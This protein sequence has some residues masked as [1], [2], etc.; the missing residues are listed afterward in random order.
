MLNTTGNIIIKIDAHAKIPDNFIQANVDALLDGEF[1]C[2]GGR[3]NIPV[4]ESPWDNVLLAAEECMFGGS[5]AKYR[6]PQTKREYIN[7]IFNGAYRREV[8][9][10]SAAL[11][12]HLVVLKTMNFITE[13][14][15]Q[16]IK[17]AVTLTL[18]RINTLEAV[19]LKW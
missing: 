15:K 2:G 8:L 7:S 16:A 3:P 1:V 5:F 18:F 9:L 4:K 6:N 14:P 12:K 19:Y 17:Y 11:T 13:L 10:K